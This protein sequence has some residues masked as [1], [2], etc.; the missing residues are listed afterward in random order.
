MMLGIVLHGAIFY[1]V[2]P[3]TTMP[4]P[5]DRTNAYVFDLLFHFI[6]SFRMST[7][8]V[9]AGFFT[10]LLIEKRG[11]RDTYKNRVFRVLF[12]FFGRTHLK[13][14]TAIW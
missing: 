4:I 14:Q 12:P 5:T 11:L 7:F 3:P 10:A 8:F 13:L 2:S 9:L 6:H 1:L